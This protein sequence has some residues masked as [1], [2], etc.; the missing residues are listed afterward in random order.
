MSQLQQKRPA[1]IARPAPTA[2]YPAPADRR[3][4]GNF[5]GGI[6][7]LAPNEDSLRVLDDSQRA[8]LA[9]VQHVWD[10]W[11]AL[12]F[13]IEFGL[14]DEKL[15]PGGSGTLCYSPIRSYAY[16]AEL[17]LSEFQFRQFEQLQQAAREPLTRRL[18]LL[19]SSSATPLI[20]EVSKLQQQMARTRPPRDLAMAVLD[21]TQRGKLGGLRLHFRL[22]TKPSSSG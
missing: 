4:A 15:W 2:I 13:A 6:N 18:E 12:A 3:S 14:I 5:G 10:R 8:K 7:L 11:D 17:G 20:S 21:E 9:G 22:R 16:A 1:A 19:N